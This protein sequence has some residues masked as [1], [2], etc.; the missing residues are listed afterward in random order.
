MNLGGWLLTCLRGQRGSAVREDRKH[1]WEAGFGLR[2]AKAAGG[3][4]LALSPDGPHRDDRRAAGH[5]RDCGDTPGAAADHRQRDR[6]PAGVDLAAGRAAR[7]RGRGELRRYLPAPLPGRPARPGRA[8][9]PAHRAL[10]LAVPAGRRAPGRDPHRAV[11]GPVH[12]RPEHGA[13][14]L[15]HGADHARQPH[16]VRAV[17]RHHGGALAGADDRDRGGRA[18]AVADR[19]RV[20]AQAV[21]RELARAAAVGRRGR[22]RRRGHRRRA[23]GQGVRPGAAGAGAAGRGEREPVR[24]PAAH[25]PA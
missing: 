14:H 8:A 23:R 18:G 2:V 20:A 5:R 24:V 25:D 16:A 21:P 7:H 10:R 4:L 17:L 3:L 11:G 1:G 13:V 22:R 12:L 6:D 9:R 15:V 19:A